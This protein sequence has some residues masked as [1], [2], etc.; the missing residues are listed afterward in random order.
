MSNKPEDQ[1]R[2]E[3]DK[4]LEKSG[5]HVCDYKN[6]NIH[7]HRGVVLRYFPLKDGK[8]ADYLFYLDGKAAGIIE[9]KKVGTTLSGVEIQSMKYTK[10][11]PDGLPTWYNP[12]P[13]AYESTGE[14]TQ[15]TNGLDPDPR[16]RNVFSFHQPDILIS[17]LA[18]EAAVDMAAE[19]KTTFN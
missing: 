17:W 3:I 16:S 7:A 6:A 15:F 14:E 9:A 19:T 2:E 1:A 13:Y 4:M 11:L 12:L 5:W 10:G 18:E 8:E